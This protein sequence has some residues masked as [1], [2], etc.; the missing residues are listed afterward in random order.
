MMY[1]GESDKNRY[2]KI[3]DGVTR[4]LV[5]FIAGVHENEFEGFI[6]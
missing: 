1:I 6:S 3:E 4:P 2:Y 5:G